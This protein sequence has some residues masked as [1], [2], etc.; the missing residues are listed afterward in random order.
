MVSKAVLHDIAKQVRQVAVD[1]PHG[2]CF[3]AS[4]A[5]RNKLAQETPADKS[6]I[7]I[8]EVRMGDLGTI[9]HYVVAYPAQHYDAESVHGRIL[10]DITLDQYSK[11]NEAAGLVDTSIADEIPSVAIYETK[12]QSP[13]TR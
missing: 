10:I 2:Q 11:A 8:E 6:E 7:V 12:Q 9:R 4:K 13:Y 1:D 5:L 3:P